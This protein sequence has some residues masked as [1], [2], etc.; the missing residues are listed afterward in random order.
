MLGILCWRVSRLR[1]TAA[2]DGICGA[3]GS[4]RGGGRVGG[5]GGD[6]GKEE[7]MGK[8]MTGNF[9]LRLTKNWP[10]ILIM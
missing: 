9:P 2:K 3:D 4:K 10:T 1:Y 8:T 6:R 5:E 7:E